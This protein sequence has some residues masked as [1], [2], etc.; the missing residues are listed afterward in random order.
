MIINMNEIVKNWAT[1][2][3][4]EFLQTAEETGGRISEFILTLM[5]KSSWAKNPKHFHT[6]QT[7]TFKVI[8]GELNLT[9]SDKHYILNPKSDKVIVEKFVY[10]SFWNATNEEVKFIAEIYPPR[11]IE[12]G[13]RLTSKLSKEGKIS[14]RNIP[15]NPFY[16]MILMNGFDSYIGFIPWKVQ[17]FIYQ[18]GA[19]L[20]KLFGYKLEL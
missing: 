18:Q 17:K 1:G 7:E 11:N 6:H 2:D 5:P 12:K 3:T 10:H 9:V 13:F 16:T 8:A 14:S 20:A 4:Y 15:Y 19:R